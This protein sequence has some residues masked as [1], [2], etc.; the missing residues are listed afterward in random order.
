MEKKLGKIKS[1]SFGHCGYDDAM[2]GLKYTL[3]GNAWGVGNSYGFWDSEIIERD[4]YCKWTEADRDKYY[5]ETMRYISKL[6]KQAKVSDVSHL[7]GIPIEATFDLNCLKE[8]RILEE[9]L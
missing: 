6:L 3:E 2:I 1:I 5:A 9:V 7:K 8:W 4:K